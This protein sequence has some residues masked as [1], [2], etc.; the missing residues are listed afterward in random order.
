MNRNKISSFQIIL[1]GFLAVILIGTGLL[2]LPAA[3]RSG[4]AAFFTEALFT[5][6][7]AVCVTG[8]VVRDTATFWSPFGKVVIL[9]LIQVGGLGVVTMATLITLFSGKRVSLR[10]KNLLMESIS[11]RQMGGIIRYMRLILLITFGTE[12][13]GAFFLLPVFAGEYGIMKGA[14]MSVFHAV[15]AFCNAGFDLMGEKAVFSSLTGYAGNVPVNLVIMILITVGGIGFQTLEDLGRHRL[16]FSRLSLQSR[17]ILITSGILVF[18]PAVIFW[19]LEY[20]QLPGKERLLASLFQSVTTRT[21]GFNTMDYGNMSEP[22]QLLVILLMLAGGSPGSTAGGIKT[23]TV[24]LLAVSAFSVFR[25]KNTDTV[26]GRRISEKTVRD[27]AAIL[28]VYSLAFLAVSGLICR[29]EGLPLLTCMFEC[30]SA[31]GTV[32]LSLG[33]TPHLGTVS[34]MFL[35]FLMVFGRVGGLTLV[36]AALPSAGIE[37]AKY[38]EEPVSVG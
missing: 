20:P 38:P 21:A 7:S 17:L 3:S 6:A 1:G 35:V 33:V 28:G 4:Q 22:G 25:R 32:G 36:C 11:A 19:F 37:Y 8:L 30:A 10:Q 13:L 26:L 29:L 5:S 18:V 14:R 2:M 27:A 9:G 31:I 34:R 24:A 23:T 15:S 12:L 16:R